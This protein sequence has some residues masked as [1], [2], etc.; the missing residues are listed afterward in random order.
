MRSNRSAITDNLVYYDMAEQSSAGKAARI[1]SAL[2]SKDAYADYMDEAFDELE[3]VPDPGA[4]DLAA[5]EL[6]LLY[7][8]SSGCKST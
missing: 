1:Q 5:N 4:L 7:A 6:L 8:V 2:A 3:S